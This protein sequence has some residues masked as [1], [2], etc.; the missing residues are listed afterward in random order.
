[1]P[2]PS[3]SQTP[4]LG[5]TGPISTKLTDL[6][7]GMYVDLNCSW[8]KHPFGC[9]TFKIAS[10]KELTTIQ[11]LDLPSV[12]VDPSL[13]DRDLAEP[14]T[15]AGFE[16]TRDAA[17]N[18]ADASP[19][20]VP[21]SDSSTDRQTITRYTEGLQQA[22]MV[23]KQTLTQSSTALND[24][25]KGS[26]AGLVTAKELVNR[27]TDLALDNTTASAMAS[28]L[29]TQDLDDMSVLHAMNV[30]VLSILVGRQF[31]LGHEQ[32]Q[33]LGIAGLLHDIGEQR[34]PPH[35]QNGRGAVNTKN[36]KD[37]QQHVDHGLSMLAQFPGL[38]DAVTDIIRQHHERIDG[39][40]YPARL[41]GNQLSLLSRIL[42]AVDEYE[43]LIN[44]AD[45]HR[46]LSPTEA[47]SQLYLT[48]KTTFSEEVVVALIQVLS[49]YPPGTVVELNDHSIGLVISINLHS[50]MRPL[51]I[52]Y[53]PTV[54]HENPNI[55]D[56]SHDPNRSIIRSIMRSELSRDVSDYLSLARW[57]GYFINSSMKALKEERT[58]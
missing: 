40:G 28:L 52:L 36:R 43:R 8:F 45:I 35:L 23:Y 17:A 9:K 18:L 30:A 32:T 50:R 1:M 19:L 2:T 53:D 20:A 37:V 22:D 51:I 26:A 46:N 29:G 57:T 48:G 7:I 3:T 4:D 31:D 15:E 6:R 11:G 49:V 5:K 34:L 10:E 38:P 12:L 56:L 42:M 44:A 27:L 55:A 58:A 24:I 41:K 39:S 47:L 16:Q 33:T 13:S 14:G 25:R 54:D 21:P